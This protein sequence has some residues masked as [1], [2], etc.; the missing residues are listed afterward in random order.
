[1]LAQSRIFDLWNIRIFKV[2][3]LLSNACVMKASIEFQQVWYFCDSNCIL[4]ISVENLT[5]HQD[6]LLEELHSFVAIQIWIRKKIYNFSL[7][8][9]RIQKYFRNFPTKFLSTYWTVLK[10]P[11]THSLLSANEDIIILSS[12]TFPKK[13]GL[14]FLKIH[15]MQNILFSQILIAI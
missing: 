13:H 11:K 3:S 12:K 9:W 8:F 6:T 7:T 10:K 5:S 1:M 15:I 4:F 14:H 2:F